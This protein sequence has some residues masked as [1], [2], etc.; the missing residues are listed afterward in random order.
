MA[1]STLPAV[2]AEVTSPRQNRLRVLD[3]GI[4]CHRHDV[5]RCQH[6]D[7]FVGS[8]WSLR[9]VGQWNRFSERRAVKISGGTGKIVA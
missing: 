3:G 5:P 9:K 4:M 7:E 2:V 8:F 1:E 6:E